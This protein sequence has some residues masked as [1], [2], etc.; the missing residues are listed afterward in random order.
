MADLRYTSKELVEAFIKRALTGDELTLLPLVGAA[1]ENEIDSVLDS[2]FGDVSESTR[3]FDGGSR[4]LNTGPVRNITAVSIVDAQETV[5]STYT[6][7]EDFEARPRNE[8]IKTYLQKRLGCFPAGLGN[9]AVTGKF[10][11]SPDDEIPDDIK[12]VATYMTAKYFQRGTTSDLKSESIEGYSRV[13]KEYSQTDEVVSSILN[14]YGAN[15]VL[16]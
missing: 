9:I 6:L 8:T 16:L 14:R 3:Y 12:Y 1:A 15:D 10:T 4:I 11:Y 5:T 13:F 7:N 2:S